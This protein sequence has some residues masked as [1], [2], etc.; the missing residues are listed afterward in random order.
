MIRRSS[1]EMPVL[2]LEIFEPRMK[3]QIKSIVWIPHSRVD[4]CMMQYD[5]FSS[6]LI[7]LFYQRD[8]HNP[9]GR[10]PAHSYRIGLFF[11]I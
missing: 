4:S 10:F 2:Q 3:S 7:D 5:S 11:I 8:L 6:S 9:S 1:L